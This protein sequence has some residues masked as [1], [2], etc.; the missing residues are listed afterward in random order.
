VDLHGGNSGRE[1]ELVCMEEQRQPLL[2][3]RPAKPS[4]TG[5]ISPY[6]GLAIGGVAHLVCLRSSAD[7]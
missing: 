6:L 3:H 4:R 5:A 2:L 7:G 1:M